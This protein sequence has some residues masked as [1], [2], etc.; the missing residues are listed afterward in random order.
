LEYAP[1]A[2]LFLLLVLLSAL[3][4]VAG[5]ALA[6]RLMPVPRRKPHTSAIGILYGGLY[7]L[8]GVI[9]GF[10]AFLVMN[11]YNAALATVQS[12]AADVAQIYELAQSLPESERNEVQRAVRHARSVL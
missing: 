11:K 6:Q 12:E 5:V 3:L 1:T 7:V 2:F 4:G 10:T 8:F 9:V